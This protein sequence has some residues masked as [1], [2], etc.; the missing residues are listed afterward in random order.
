MHLMTEVN[1]TIHLDK[2][3]STIPTEEVLRDIQYASIRY[4]NNPSS[5]Y[6][7]GREVKRMI[8]D[9]KDK[10]REFINAKPED[11]II[12]CASGTEANNLGMNIRTNI[13][14]DNTTHP[15]M[16]NNPNKAHE[17]IV[18]SGGL[19]D[20]DKL[21]EIL[22]YICYY[23][24]LVAIAYTSSELGIRHYI[25]NISKVVHD[26][27]GILMVDAAQTIGHKTIDVQEEGID[28]LTFTSEKI[29]MPRGLGILY[30]KDG[31]EI[32]P[33]MYGGH[34]E[35]NLRPSTENQA[36]IYALGNR[37][38]YINKNKEYIQTTENKLNDYFMQSIYNACKYVCKYKING[39]DANC[40]HY[41]THI[42]SIQ[43]KGYKASD[44]ITML[45]INGTEC[46]AGSACSS[47]ESKPSRVLKAIG[48]T[49]EEALST[50]RF[51][52]DYMNTGEEIKRFEGI[53][54]KCLI[55]L[56]E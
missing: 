39:S 22:N 29:Q 15:S 37:L 19:I 28:I 16:Y 53:L 35:Y 7:S 54:R 56:K 43:F 26:N 14:V 31:I 51:S 47:G 5:V 18:N 20:L 25:P 48:L 24:C 30:V 4:W 41:P 34:Q 2:A 40:Y 49:D 1:K 36:M 13:I 3:A 27:G 44:L 45:D 8:E 11:K 33:I 9:V 38:E 55:A 21:K 17:S 32:N 50:V 6:E 23:N 10:V 52:F 46:S 42:A 12:F